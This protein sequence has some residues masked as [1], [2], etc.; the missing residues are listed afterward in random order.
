MMV[1]SNSSRYLNCYGLDAEY[2]RKKEENYR[3]KGVN[4]LT[5]FP[6][7]VILISEKNQINQK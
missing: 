5:S 4:E 2:R 7:R 1:W 6:E 3:F